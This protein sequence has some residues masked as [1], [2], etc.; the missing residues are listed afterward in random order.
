MFIFGFIIQDYNFIKIIVFIEVTMSVQHFILCLDKNVTIGAGTLIT[1]VIVNNPSVDCHFHLYAKTKDLE[2]IQKLLTPRFSKLNFKNLQITYK[3]IEDFKTMQSIR[4]K[5]SN[6]IKK[7][8]RNLT[9]AALYR[10]TVLNELDF[11][12]DKV[13]YLDTDILCTGSLDS[14]FNLDFG[15]KAIGAVSDCKAQLTYA[16]DVLNFTGDG[17]YNS[18]V[19]VVNV[20]RWAEFDIGNRAV[21]YL[22]E[23]MPKQIDQ[24]ALNVASANHVV[25][26]ESIYNSITNE[27]VVPM[28]G[29]I[30]VHCTGAE[31]PWKP[32]IS[33]NPQ[34]Y[35]NRSKRLE[36][37][38]L[39]SDEVVMVPDADIS[40]IVRVY[41][42]YLSTFEPDRSKWYSLTSDADDILWKPSSVHD[43][44]FM[45]KLYRKN[46]M[47]GQAFYCWLKHYK[48]KVQ[49]MGL[50]SV[51]LG[52]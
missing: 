13:I 48:A 52:K 21:Q 45:S 16:K 51:L 17:Y 41:R 15:D 14:I 6:V 26:L 33:E 7:A 23:K 5:L 38:Q 9:E 40:E 24:D 49:R 18:G 32:W 36:Q 3:S 1:S 30:L 37:L 10:I 46:G 19:L 34:D 11:A 50:M 47:L 28:E 4:S 44:K 31:K 35:K 27:T 25:W 8:N 20:K 42:S 29:S 43:F 12:A 2:I 39:G 22:I